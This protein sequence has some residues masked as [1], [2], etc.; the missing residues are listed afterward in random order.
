[1]VSF[2]I[3]INTIYYLN[4]Y[5]RKY[6]YRERSKIRRSPELMK[7]TLTILDFLIEQ[8]EVS[9]YLMREGIV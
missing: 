7:H 4:A 8:G 6:L 3:K 5:I 9:G 2:A 1:M